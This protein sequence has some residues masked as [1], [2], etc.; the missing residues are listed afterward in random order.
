MD[1]SGRDDIFFLPSLAFGRK[2]DIC[3]RDDHFFSVF[4]CFWGI[5][6]LPTIFPT[7]SRSQLLQVGLKI[8]VRKFWVNDPFQNLEFLDVLHKASRVSPFGFTTKNFIETAAKHRTFV[9]GQSHHPKHFHKSNEI[10]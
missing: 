8:T 3:G 5:M 7:S 2:M 1:I 6:F 9:H 4:T 10:A